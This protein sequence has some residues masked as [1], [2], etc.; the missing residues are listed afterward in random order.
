MKF[1]TCVATLL[2]GSALA[3]LPAAVHAAEAESAESTDPNAIIVTSQKI[4]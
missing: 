1:G 3:G 2:A 4:E